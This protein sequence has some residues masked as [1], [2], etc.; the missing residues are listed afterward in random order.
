VIDILKIQI[1]HLNKIQG[2]EIYD[3]VLPSAMGVIRRWW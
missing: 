2:A 3:A 1:I